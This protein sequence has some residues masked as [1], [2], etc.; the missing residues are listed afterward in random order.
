MTACKVHDKNVLRAKAFEVNN[1]KTAAQ[2]TQRDFFKQ[3]QE[4]VATVSTEQLRS[5]FGVKPKE[6]SRRNALAAQVAAA[7]SVEG[8]VKSVDF[9]KLQAIGNGE[10]VNTPIASIS[11]GEVTDTTELTP[12]MFN[13][14]EEGSANIIL[15][16]FDT[17][18]NQI[19]LINTSSFVYEEY[20][21]QGFSVELNGVEN[22]YFYP[23]CATS[24]NDVSFNSF[25]SFIIKTRAEKKSR[26]AGSDTPRSG[27]EVSLN[28]ATTGSLARLDFRNYDFN[29][30]IPGDLYQGNADDPTYLVSHVAWIEAAD[31]KWT[32]ELERDYDNTKPTFLEIKQGDTV[33]DTVPFSVVVA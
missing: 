32:S 31:N 18:K 8:N 28:G 13:I 5:L 9:S 10:K 6:M 12:S 26:D 24:N 27:D 20:T 22:G 3:V 30:L 7:F 21:M 25:G 19:K 11:N 4:I 16:V 1:P 23:T 29:N 17:D 33:I 15:V 14:P 2:T